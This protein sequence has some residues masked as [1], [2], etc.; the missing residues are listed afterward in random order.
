MK[1]YIDRHEYHVIDN[2]LGGRLLDHQGLHLATLGRDDATGEYW[3]VT[4]ASGE[5]ITRWH[6]DNVID[7]LLNED[8]ARAY[9]AWA[10]DN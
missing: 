7:N 10:E 4:T 3:V 6:E 1:I 5:Y 8:F 2:P 9:V